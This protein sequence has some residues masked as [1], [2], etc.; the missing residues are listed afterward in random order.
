ANG[1][2][3]LQTGEISTTKY[4]CNGATGATGSAGAAGKN[5]LVTAVDEGKGGNC[6]NGGKKI[7]YGTDAN[8][9]GA[10]DSSEVSGTTYLCELSSSGSG[11]GSGSSSSSSC[12]VNGADPNSMNIYPASPTLTK[13]STQSFIAMGSYANNCSLDLT[14]YAWW[15]SNDNSTLGNAS[16]AATFTASDNGSSTVTATFGTKYATT[17][18][19]LIDKL[20]SSLVIDNTTITGRVDMM[21]QLTATGTYTDATTADLTSTANWYTSNTSAATVTAGKV[22]ISGA[23]NAVISVAYGN[24]GDTSKVTGTALVPLLATKIGA[25][26]DHSCGLQSD[27]SVK[28]WGSNSDGQLG[29][30]STTDSLTPVTMSNI[31][32]SVQ[33]AAGF[34]HNCARFS[35]G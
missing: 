31:S 2:G 12:S 21:K 18:V 26:D 14:S 22:I 20:L 4:V 32:S 13:G 10:L 28:C 29:N 9:N 30:G 6:I 1:D 15:E 33:I 5:G 17:S 11:S 35:N 8:S 16:G 25:G 24:V 19:T 7:S 27:G 23:G 3:T 34:Y